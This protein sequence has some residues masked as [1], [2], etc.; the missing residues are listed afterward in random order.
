M[1][2]RCGTYCVAWERYPKGI[3]GEGFTDINNECRG[4]MA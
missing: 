4:I 3:I 1:I 2:I